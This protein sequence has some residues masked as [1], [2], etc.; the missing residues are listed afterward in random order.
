M[1]T[2]YRTVSFRALLDNYKAEVGV[3]EQETPNEKQE[4]EIFLNSLMKSPIIKEVHKY[5][6]SIRLA[7]RTPRDFKELLRKLWFT[8]YRRGRPNDSSAFEHVF[9][10]EIKNGKV[11]GFHNWI[12]FCDQEAKGEIDYHGFYRA[13]NHE[14]AYK[15]SL[16]F[17]WKNREKP[18]STLLF[19]ASVDFEISLYTTIYLISKREFGSMRSWPDVQVSIGRDKIRV[20]CHDF[21]GHIGS[22]YIK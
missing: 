15:R 19:G 4:Q 10:G 3:S 7:P 18:L 14:P 13:H 16:R 9:V 2:A 20:Q 22:C 12:T 5:L 21:R 11:S 17:T 8:P 6:V 1:R